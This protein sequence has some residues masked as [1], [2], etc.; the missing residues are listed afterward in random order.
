MDGGAFKFEEIEAA[1]HETAHL[2]PLEVHALAPPNAKLWRETFGH[3][4]SVGVAAALHAALL[5]AMLPSQTD[6]FGDDGIALETIAVSIVD[7]LPVISAPETKPAETSSLVPDVDEP[8]PE[9]AEETAEA[10]KET[11]KEPEPL[12]QALALDLPPE[13][14]PPPPEAITLPA[15]EPDAK[16]DTEVVLRE[17]PPEPKKEDVVKPEPIETAAPQP[18]PQ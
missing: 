10:A 13:P 6:A 15:R 12:K 18:P 7:S 1:A 14:V 9:A 3:W 16:P 17:P 11:P 5:I 8:Q 4:L 2:P